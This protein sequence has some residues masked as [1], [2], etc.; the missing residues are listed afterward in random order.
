MPARCGL[1]KANGKLEQH[2]ISGAG[3]GIRPLWLVSKR[4]P[5]EDP[6]GPSLYRRGLGLIDRFVQG[7]AKA[8]S[9]ARND[10]HGMRFGHVL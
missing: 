2:Q 7:Q 3:W 9:L 8:G 5:G 10:F 1:G 4:P 6:E